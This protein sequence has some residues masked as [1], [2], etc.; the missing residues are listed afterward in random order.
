MDFP[1]VDFGGIKLRNSP[2]YN[3]EARNI[4]RFISTSLRGPNLWWLDSEQPCLYFTHK[5]ALC[6]CVCEATVQA[7]LKLWVPGQWYYN[8]ASWRHATWIWCLWLV[9][10]GCPGRIS[11]GNHLKWLRWGRFLWFSSVCTAKCWDMTSNRLNKAFVHMFF[12]SLF[13]DCLTIWRHLAW[14]TDTIIKYIKN[15]KKHKPPRC[16]LS[17]SGRLL[18]ICHRTRNV[19]ISVLCVSSGSPE[20]H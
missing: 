2:A 4:R 5:P 19:I 3:S 12:S 15:K 18:Q 9:V 13:I 6:L 20:K 11:T 10:G 16:C 17:F 14:V 1:V 8:I 7:N